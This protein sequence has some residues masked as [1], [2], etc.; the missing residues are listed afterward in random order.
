MKF[1]KNNAQRGS[2]RYIVFKPKDENEWY[3]VALEFNIVE[4]GSDPRV[5]LVRLFEAIQGYVESFK[6]I[7]GAR[8]HTLNQSPDSE[9]EKM[10]WKLRGNKPIKSPYI[11][12]T[13]GEK[14]LARA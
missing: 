4:S 5:A 6:K 2:V 7:T 11:V 8:P 1:F 3:A 13:F 12:D 9:Y 14:N 10:W